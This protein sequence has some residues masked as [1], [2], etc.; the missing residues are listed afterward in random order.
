[1]RIVR[2][3]PLFIIVS[4]F[5]MSCSKNRHEEFGKDLAKAFKSK[6]YKNFDTTEYYQVFKQEL[7]KLKPQLHDPNWISKI[8]DGN[9]KGLILMGEFLI[10]GEIDTLN[11]FLLNAR[12]HGLN[13]EYFHAQKSQI[14]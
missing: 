6:E 12:F 5:L 4:L 1:M 2:I 13:P 14:F 10:N 7:V 3:L 9:E 11:Q 8:Y